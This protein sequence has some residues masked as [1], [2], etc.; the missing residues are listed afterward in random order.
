MQSKLQILL[1]NQKTGTA[2]KTGNA[3]DIREAHCILFNDDG[4]PGAVGVLNVPKAL[5]D[6]AVPGM[7]TASFGLEA[8]TFGENQGKIVAVLADLVAMPA[9]RSAASPAAAAKA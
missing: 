8:P 3:Y 1:V 2:K 5:L 6:K 9:A 7:Y 4:T